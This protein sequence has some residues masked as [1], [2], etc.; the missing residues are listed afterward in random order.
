MFLHTNK[1][2]FRYEC[3]LHL[4]N[5]TIFPNFTIR[6]PKTG[7]VFYWE[8]FGLIDNTAYCQNMHSKLQL[9]TS[10][11]I[12]PSI[13]LIATFETQSHPLCSEMVEKIIEYYFL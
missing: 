10:H 2:P 11:G 4:G 7:K 5:T 12:M 13:Q 1:I 6:H 3:I 8:H 9:Y